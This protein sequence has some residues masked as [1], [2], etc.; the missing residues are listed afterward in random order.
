MDWTICKPLVD[1]IC[2]TMDTATPDSWHFESAQ[3][4]LDYANPKCEMGFWVPSD[5]MAAVKVSHKQCLNIFGGLVD[6]T[7]NKAHD[8]RN[9]PHG[10]TIN[11]KTNPA[12]QEGQIP[13]ENGDGTG[14]LLL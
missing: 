12:P 3:V 10:A 1:T 6:A 11:L 8:L 9:P 4:D 2:K 5:P 7:L 13:L 14:E